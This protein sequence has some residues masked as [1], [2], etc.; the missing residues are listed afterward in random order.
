MFKVLLVDDEPFVTKALKVL[1]DWEEL[2]YSI[3]GEASHGE[4][5]VEIIKELKPDV[6]ITDI[7]MPR[8]DGL[9]LIRYCSE[10]LKANS[11]FIVLSGY[12]DFKYAQ[13]AIKYRVKEYL[14]KPI[15]ED[16]LVDRLKELSKE[17]LKKKES[18]EESYKKAKLNMTYN[19]Y[20]NSG[21]LLLQED[22]TKLSFN[23]SFEKIL[24]IRYI[25]EAID[26]GEKS[27]I[28]SIVKEVFSQ[29]YKSLSTVEAIKMYLNSLIVE[30]MKL[31]NEVGGEVDC[32]MQEYSSFVSR[33]EDLNFEETKKSTLNLCIKCISYI[34]SLKDNS[35]RGVINEVE[36]YIKKHYMEDIN[37]KLISEKFYMNPVYL[38]Q[39]FKKYFGKHFNDYINEMRIEEAKKLLTRTNK[40]IY[41]ISEAVG[42]KNRDYFV[43]RFQ[44]STN[45]TPTEYKRSLQS[46][47]V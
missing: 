20:R 24:S 2:G 34:K 5:A 46:L 42:Y 9:E 21:C 4:E 18:L 12:N 8:M 45:M 38:G 1:I 25:I 36:K 23:Y 32:F 19:F 22:I 7:R 40:K 28:E 41:E 6:V 14:L 31:I 27:N 17:F 33:I 26:K 39:Q 16:E 43:G 10:V 47:S 13:Q 3:C 15:D 30:L 11:E 35:S 44:K 29:F 37:L